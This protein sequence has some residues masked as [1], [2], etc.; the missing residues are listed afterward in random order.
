MNESQTT[1]TLLPNLTRAFL[2]VL[3]V[4]LAL[5]PFGAIAERYRL[6]YWWSPGY[7]ASLAI[8]LLVMPTAVCL[9]F[10]PRHIKWSATEFE[11]QP[12]FGRVRTLPWTQLYAFGSGNN[13][14]LIQFKDVPTFQ[15]FAGAFDREQ[16]RALRAFLTTSHPDK[17]A[18]LWLGP[19]A[20]RK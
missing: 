11:I 20:I 3:F 7:F 12:R 16:W 4:C 19:K 15:I 1:Q 5:I 13:V 10:V 9:I 14:F 2:R 18:S 8:P 17:K 6:G